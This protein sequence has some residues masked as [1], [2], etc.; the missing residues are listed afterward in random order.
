VTIDLPKLNYYIISEVSQRWDVP[1]SQILRWG[2]D[3]SVPI[4]TLLP[5]GEIEILRMETF[6]PMQDIVCDCAEVIDR[7][8]PQNIHIREFISGNDGKKKREKK[9]I[10]SAQENI[11]ASVDDVLLSLINEHGFT[12]LDKSDKLYGLKDRDGNTISCLFLPEGYYFSLDEFPRLSIDDLVIPGAELLRIE[13]KN[14]EAKSNISGD[15]LGTKD[16]EKLESMV[17][18]MAIILSRK[19]HYYS[20]GK[21]PNSKMIAEEIVALNIVDRERGTIEKTI[22]SALRKYSKK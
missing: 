12:T 16:R 9:I 2:M 8:G 17:A 11:L 10:I 5:R 1:I 3:Q 19:I 13:R 7:L 20:H 21:S 14:E 6:V 22:S 4:C 15:L 18:A